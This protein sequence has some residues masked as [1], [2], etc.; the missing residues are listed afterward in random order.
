[1]QAVG[2]LVVDVLLAAVLAAAVADDVV[3]S[4]K[5]LVIFS[6]SG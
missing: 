6:N 3:H 2:R 4:M 5:S 1:V